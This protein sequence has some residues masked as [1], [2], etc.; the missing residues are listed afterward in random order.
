MTQFYTEEELKKI[1]FA[2]VGQNV[3]IFK[4]AKF[5]HPEKI[6]IG[7]NAQIDDFCCLCGPINIGNFVHIAIGVTVYGGGLLIIKDYAN[8]SA[9]TVIV[10]GTD[11][12]NG[13]NLIGPTI[14]ID[15]RDI[16]RYTMTFGEYSLVGANCTINPGVNIGEGGCLGSHS[17][18]TK[19][20]ESWMIY[21]GV[22]AKILKERVRCNQTV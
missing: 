15:R 14:P 1:G 3:K 6:F 7:N 2:N 11:N 8:I 17:L 19:N 4:L 18:A 12:F 9:R 16:S 10:T 5:V 22:P 21:G 13:D 20:L